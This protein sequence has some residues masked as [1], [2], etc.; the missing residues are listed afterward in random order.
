MGN[1]YPP[2]EHDFSSG[3][4]ELG[5]RLF[6]ENQS[7][8]ARIAQLTHI[9]SDGCRGLD[10]IAAL[11]RRYIPETHREAAVQLVR[12]AYIRGKIDGV[13]ETPAALP[14]VIS[15]CPLCRGKEG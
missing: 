13:T 14:L 10:D 5:Q 12:L 11:T 3:P 15:V 4:Y 6:E 8:K 7:L 1:L 2:T 9:N